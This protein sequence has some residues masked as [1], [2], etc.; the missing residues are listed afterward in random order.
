MKPNKKR[1]QQCEE[2]GEFVSEHFE[3]GGQSFWTTCPVCSINVLA[4][5]KRESREEVRKIHQQ[6]R[7]DAMSK[8]LNAA[9]VPLRFKGASFDNYE[10]TSERQATVL[11]VVQTYADKFDEL[12]QRGVSMVFAGDSGTGKTHLACAIGNQIMREGH[13]FVFIGMRQAIAQ[14]RGSWGSDEMSEDDV[15]KRF[16]EPDLLVLDEIGVQHGTESEKIIMFEI[17][18]GRYERMKSTI[19]MTNLP[20]EDDDPNGIRAYLGVRLFDRIRQDGGRVLKFNWE[21]HRGVAQ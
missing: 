9:G 16:I 14:V 13:T 11:K 1:K 2:H 5:A 21:S 12:K 20:A 6:N 3:M 10:A 7:Q 17:I 19:L 8:R 18:N 15:I 4:E